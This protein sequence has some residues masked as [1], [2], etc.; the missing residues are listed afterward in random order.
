MLQQHQAHDSER[1]NDVYRYYGYQQCFHYRSLRSAARQIAANSST[2]NEAPPISPP[3][4]SFIA[5]NSA[6]FC[7]FTLPP[8]RIATSCAILASRAAN[9][10][11]KNAC[12]SCACS[13]EAVL[14]VPIA[15]TGSY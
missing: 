3:S 10:D 2:F 6:A 11:R 15:H 1:G 13:G 14:P 4:I 8:Y 5:N 9:S 7:A 12:T